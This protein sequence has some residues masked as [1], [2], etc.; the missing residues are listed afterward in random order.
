[1]LGRTPIKT[2]S[3]A[4]ARDGRSAAGSTREDIVRND[5]SQHCKACTDDDNT[6]MV[7]CDKCDDW[8]HFACVEVSR[9]VADR[10]W[11]CPICQSAAK[12][13]K[14]KHSSKVTSTE[15]AV[16][17]SAPINPAIRV[18]S[19]PLNVV[20]QIP[21][22]LPALPHV[23][24]CDV[25][26]SVLTHVPSNMIFPPVS[27]NKASNTLNPLIAYTVTS[28]P[29]PSNMLAP[30]G[31]FTLAG[32]SDSPNPPYTLMSSN[33]VIQ[34]TA[35]TVTSFPRM[36]E[37]SQ[38]PPI[39]SGA[40]PIP[41]VTNIPLASSTIIPTSG[42]LA[43]KSS[44][45]PLKST[46]NIPRSNAKQVFGETSSQHSGASK[47][48]TKQ[49]QLELELKMLDEERKLQEEENLK[50]REYLQ[51]R[52][53]ILLE[54]ASESSS[55]AEIEEDK[56]EDRVDEWVNNRLNA[57]PAVPD[58]EVLP[59]LLDVNIARQ[60]PYNNAYPICSQPEISRRIP[61]RLETV[62]FRQPR[63]FPTSATDRYAS[64][65]VRQPEATAPQH[66]T[67]NSRI[68]RPNANHQPDR[69]SRNVNLL[70]LGRSSLGRDL[71][72]DDEDNNLTRSQVVA[73]QAVS[74]ELPTFSGTPEEW[75][76]FFS[77]FT[78]TT[79]MCG[80]TA[81]ENLVRLQ[82]CLTGKAFEAV[83]CMLM[84]PMNV[85]QIISTLKMRFGNPEIIVHNLMAKISS[86][87]A[88]KA[89]K[90]DT[91]IE[92]ALAVQNLCAT[93][94]ACQLEEYSYNVALLRELVDKL[95]SAIKLDWARY[96][97]NFAAVNLSIF[98][99]W[100]YEL[101]EDIC[102]LAGPPSDPKINRVGKNNPAF[103]NAHAEEVDDQPRKLLKEG[104]LTDQFKKTDAACLVCKSNC[105]TIDKCQRFYEMGYNSRWAVVKEFGLCRKCLN[106]HKGPCKI[107]KLCGKNGCE[108]KHHEL[109]HN[110]L[111]DQKAAVKTG[112][113]SDAPR[114]NLAAD[115]TRSSESECN[116]HHQITNKT[117]FRV[118][119]V[120]LY[121]PDKPI[122][123]FA[124]LDDGSS[125]TLMDA[126]LAMELKVEGNH[127]PL[128]L[129]WTGNMC[130]SEN[131]SIK[132]NVQISGTGPNAKRYWLQG[133]HTVSALDLFRQSVD[134]REMADHYKHLRG[135]PVES[136]QNAQPRILIG[137]KNANLGYPLKGR[138]GKP[139][140]PIATKTRLGWVLHGGC[141]GTDLLLAYH[142]VQCG[143]SETSD[144]FLEQTIREY[145]SLEGLGVTKQD[146]PLFSKED[147]RALEILHKIVQ[148][149]N[150]QYETRLLWKYDEFR[151]PN[152]KPAA[153]RRLHCLES[154]M[155]REPELAVALRAKIEDYKEKGYIRKLVEAELQE[156]QRIWYI[157]IF[158]VF[159]A[160]KPGK[161]RIV[162]DCAAKTGNVSL[163]SMLV[164]GPDQ[165]TP[166]TDVLYRFRENKIGISGDIREMFLQVR[167][168]KEDQGCQLF[169]WK[170]DPEDEVPSTY[171]SQVMTFGACCSPSCAQFVKNL[172]ATKYAGKFP[173][174]AEAI[175]KQH[176]VDDML[177]SVE[178]EEEAIQL[179]EDVRFIHAE[180]GF[181][182][183]NWISNS[184]DVLQA[185]H[186]E[187]TDNKSLHVGSELG[188]EKVL[189]MWWCTNT[190]SFTYKLSPKHDA[191]L[192]TGNR[193]PTKRE[194]LRTLMSIFDP[195]GLLSHV[196]VCIKI[197]FQEIW[198]SAI[199]WDDAIPDKLHE[200]WDQWLRILPKLKDVNIPRC[201]RLLTTVGP[202]TL[203]QLHTFVD[204]SELSYAAVVYLRFQQ[205]NTVECA[206]VG[207]K[208]RV[209]PLKFISIPRLELQSAV[210]GA[211]LANTIT[212]ALSFKI[213]ERFFWT[214]ARDVLCWLRS[215]HRQY[216]PFVGWRV[217]EILEETN[218]NNW[219][220]ISSQDNVADEATKCK[221]TPDLSSQSRWFRGPEF[222][223]K[224]ADTWPCEPFSSNTTK[225]ELRANLLFHKVVPLPLFQVA[226]FS[227]WNRLLRV[228]AAT[229]RFIAN[230]RCKTAGVDRSTGPF[231]KD[232]LLSASNLL[233]RQAQSEAFAE[234]IA[235]LSNTEKPIPK[236][237]SIF[238]M[239]PFLD[240]NRVLRMHGR[241]SACEY[242][243][244]DARN[245]I[246][247]PKDH[248]I[249]KLIVQDYHQRYHHRNHE[250][251][252]N[253]LRQ[254]F[255]IPKLRGMFRKVKSDCQTCKNQRATPLLP[256]M[257]DLPSARLA[258]YTRPFS[259]I[260]I[261]Y[262]GP[263]TVA[264]GRKNEKRWGVLITCLTIRAVHIEVA[265]SLSAD[266]CIMA[267]RSFMARRGV[268]IQIYSDRGTNFIAASKE[269]NEAL[270]DMDQQKVIQE[271]SSQ[272]TEWTF[273][274][275]AS[276]HMGGAWERLIQTVKVNLQKMLPMRHPTDEVLRSTLAEIENLI[277]SR[278]LTHVP[279]DDPEAPVL[280]P[281]HF[282]LGSSSGLK[283]A[284]RLDD[285]A[286]ILRRSWRQS[287]READ[288]FW[289]RW[290]RDYL[291]VLTKRTKW[292]AN[293]KPIEHNDIVM[294]VDPDLPR[295]CWLRGRVI[296][297]NQAK[298]GHVR[299]VAVQ[300]TKGIYERP[301]SKIAVLDVRREEPV[302][303][304]PGVLGGE[305]YDPSVDAAHQNNIF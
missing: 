129:K 95:P 123:T 210:L 72:E 54:I 299:S 50:K 175:T 241:I 201:Y 48:S 228:A 52:Y 304:N 222:L 185:L 232:E 170:D 102:P 65:P 26:E 66:Q 91:I 25:N 245:P 64:M 45:E 33:A 92:F 74:R 161:L 149:D 143:C 278:P 11:H 112:V 82:K 186:Q 235:M 49:K 85:T 197:L 281:N 118:V 209:A 3:T 67:V 73:R 270:R 188:T 138:E 226:K 150:G 146:K 259:Y 127:E 39:S 189:G 62:S 215:D 264:V 122:R 251:V 104:T 221:R 238:T 116:I 133:V 60:P 4:A 137:M 107:Q 169:L 223:W 109:L 289:Q 81:E 79:S 290:L 192:L 157:P 69:Q 250:T 41:A 173:R 187:K 136:Y 199:D 292:F 155:K 13:A 43:G 132:V 208:S 16:S 267:L 246:I 23:T 256:P 103:L 70:G 227:V 89:E 34:S 98:S 105:P 76:L 152:S 295:N 40:Q 282:I 46:S 300:T 177:D 277:N 262:F 77:S 99:G 108:F 148:T 125:Y 258:A 252:L 225:E 8:Y 254:V 144:D 230:V 88:P 244:T 260:G 203:I 218:I 126:D 272:H 124:F 285:R 80:Y 22:N 55:V 6:R 90:L 303:Q 37:I 128:C 172:N 184:S 42:P 212:E 106:T 296:A 32:S 287:Q 140:E 154:R 21:I 243:S 194:V 7:Q 110:N 248:H 206:I 275:P 180:A 10:D 171:V 205:G 134:A 20:P 242:A 101:A 2:R 234:E 121:G 97:R 182:M 253:E 166:L 120:I 58:P 233:Y 96:R 183:R 139:N 47:R 283:P 156:L 75:P 30:P 1:M 153:L 214:D 24:S 229:I 158:P 268:P 301:A 178:S 174:A 288:L 211:R 18:T 286:L 293:V 14:K 193:I 53:A 141:D 291:P 78:T 63:M 29:V 236:S 202:D 117:L 151:L 9:G 294:I 35:C 44:K 280:T 86:T 257:A 83:K 269:L 191:E 196:L 276:P 12:G 164:K 160:N 181:E 247:L 59:E 135:I 130:R 163:N 36:T 217:S 255:R 100:L 159:N 231:S 111:R 237:S 142:G 239:N 224:S 113:K 68:H 168:A 165:L 240:K 38:C 274:P 273:I 71:F 302:D 84:H 167:I 162:W 115:T 216:S 19:V 147:Q 204:A 27:A 176:Y 5:G 17:T 279:V 220:W 51:K 195:L 249:S 114:E 265:H 31:I 56:V 261:D 297:V 213:N 190:D 15:P 119:P 219:K 298:D 57:G 207:A 61:A 263:M 200:K 305:C 145:F 87:P 266:S 94:E 179:A 131:D 198:R 271:I 284:S 93:I 28:T